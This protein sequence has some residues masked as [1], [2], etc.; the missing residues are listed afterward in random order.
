M[1]TP[2][3]VATLQAG[4]TDS[5][6]VLWTATPLSWTPETDPSTRPQHG[7]PV[8]VRDGEGR[9]ARPVA[10][11]QGVGGGGGWPGQD[12]AGDQA[13]QDQQDSHPHLVSRRLRY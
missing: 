11:D 9:L 6:D 13:Q 8:T 7:A 5:V 10:P 3:V 4:T 2:P 12:R 1:L